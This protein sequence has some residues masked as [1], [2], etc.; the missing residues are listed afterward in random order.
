[1]SFQESFSHE[2]PHCVFQPASGRGSRRLFAR[3][4][5]FL[6]ACVLAWSGWA[7]GLSMSSAHADGV[8]ASSEITICV[9]PLGKYDKRLLAVAQRGIA[10]LYGFTVKTLPARK[11]PKKAYYKPRRR[12]RA[13]K[14]LDYL[15]DKVKTDK[16]FAVIGFTKRDIST[17]KGKRKDWGILGLGELG[18]TA[19]VV[20]S[21][22]ATRKV[23]RRKGAM[24]TV[25]VMNH[26]LGHVLG[27]DHY[28]GEPGCV[29]NDAKGTVATVDKEKGLL[30]AP[31][32]AYLQKTHRIALPV[33]KT[34]DWDAISI[35][36]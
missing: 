10:Y 20:S 9:V 6:L 11:M 7:P 15:N 30:C 36:R 18:G 23:S 16:C 34:F 32:R 8:R 26:E 27:L 25:K 22:R 3:R 29:M 4:V 12:Y 2:C 21:Y 13:E 19:A 5:G 14:I 24:R 28:D 33:H 1:M 17:T 31:S 35:P